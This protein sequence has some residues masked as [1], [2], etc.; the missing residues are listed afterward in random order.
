MGN[1]RNL[2]IALVLS[3]S[4]CGGGDEGMGMISGSTTASAADSGGI[5][6]PAVVSPIVVGSKD[7]GGSLTIDST[8][9]ATKGIVTIAPDGG[10]V[11]VGTRTPF[12]GARL[13]VVGG[14]GAQGGV[15]IRVLDTSIPSDLSG[16]FVRARLHLEP[17]APGQRLGAFVSGSDTLN[18]AGMIFYSTEAWTPTA[19][20]TR[21]AFLTTPNGSAT[22]TE[23]MTINNGNVGIATSNP[24]FPLDVNGTLRAASVVT[25][26]DARLKK[27]VMSLDGSLDRISRLR[28]VTFEWKHGKQESG[29]QM[30]FV[31]QEVEQVYPEL[32][33]SDGKGIKSLDYSHLVVPLVEAVKEMRGKYV[34]QQREIASLRQQLSRICAKEPGICP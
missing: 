13:D 11:G 27:T 15:G 34:E 8:A 21:I 22:R 31:A 25:P 26:S 24:A 33:S 10:N 14:G 4:A 29:R 20:G 5:R 12:P 3:M 2:L 23:Y 28:G 7:P 17:T 32:V 16:P 1:R 30:G 19:K 9:D 6:G 18:S